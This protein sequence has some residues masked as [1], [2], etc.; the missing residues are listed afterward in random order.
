MVTGKLLKRRWALL[1][2][3]AAGV[4]SFE[5]VDWSNRKS[6]FPRDGE[7]E[8]PPVEYGQKGGCH[9]FAV[10][11][12]E[13]DLEL[14]LESRELS[15][16]PSAFILKPGQRSSLRIEYTAPIMS[17][18]YSVSY[19]THDGSYGYNSQF[20]Y[21]GHGGGY[22]HNSQFGYNS[23]GG[24][25]AGQHNYGS[26]SHSMRKR[27][28]FNV[29]TGSQTKNFVACIQVG[30]VNVKASPYSKPELEVGLMLPEMPIV[31]P[32]GKT[33]LSALDQENKVKEMEMEIRLSNEGS[34]PCD[35]TLPPQSALLA[36][37]HPS[38]IE[39]DDTSTT[40]HLNA[41]GSR[42]LRLLV[43][44]RDLFQLGGDLLVRT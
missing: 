13:C 22:G 15:I 26:Y 41:H 32:S 36:R 18:P 2:A 3:G 38:G 1:P 30:D 44:P 16:S 37:W 25:Y 9:I 14:K 35:L 34:L 8:L 24:G 42:G 27:L 20:G 10:N 12:G 7:F 11:G 31:L 39:S 28:E 33:I 17:D 29:I 5:T 4:P 40:R 6:C 43:K 23:H 19:N 21:H